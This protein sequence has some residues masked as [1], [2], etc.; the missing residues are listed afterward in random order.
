MCL[1]IANMKDRFYQWDTGQHLIVEEKCREIHFSQEGAK[2]LVCQIKEE[3]GKRVVDVPNILLQKAETI[4]AYVVS[5]NEE[6]AET[7]WAKSFRVQAR[8]RPE[9]YVYTQTEVLHFSTLV[10]RLEKLEGEG[11]SQAVEAYLKE[12]PVEAGATAEEAKQIQQNKTN[13]EQLAQEKLDASKLPEAVNDALAQAKASGE[14]KGDPGAPGEKG[15]PGDDYVLTEADKQKIAEMTAPLVDVPE[16]G[17]VSKYPDWS[18]L[19]WYVMGDSLTDRDSKNANGIPFT[20]KYYYDFVQE[21]TGIQLV[22]DGIGGTGY[23][24]GVSN[25]PPDTFLHRVENAFPENDLTKNADV[26]VVTIF[27]SVNDIKHRTDN[28]D[29]DIYDTLAWLSLKRPGLRVIVVPPSLCKSNDEYDFRKRETL[30]KTYCERLQLCALACDFRYLS[31]MYD[32]PPFNPNL[33]GLVV[34]GHMAKF[35]TTDPSGIHPN[36]EGHKALAPY[37]YNALLQELALKV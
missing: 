25:N 33:N 1:K 32:C 24:A 31:D 34:P 29:R 4:T 13:I 16:G 21:K 3:N 17:N 8:P 14:F 23:G 20:T 9:N 10:D 7:V 19:K 26:D 5:E 37:F 15:A 27:G 30:W 28:T 2:A 6:G 12:N 22:V 35:F 36:E 18:H 11:I